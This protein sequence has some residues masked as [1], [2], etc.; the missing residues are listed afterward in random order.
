MRR[1][2]DHDRAREQM[3]DRQIAARGVT[4][5]AVL[6]AMRTVP[7]H[8]FVPERQVRFAYDDSPQPIGRGQTISQP[9]V[10]AWMTEAAGVGPDSRVLEVGTGSGY[11]A[12]VLGQIAREV[13]TIET[14]PELA[15]SAAKRLEDLGY[16]NVTVVEGDGT[17]GLPEHAPFDAIVVTAGGPRIPPALL[18]QLAEGGRLVI[19]VESGLGDQRLVCVRR[20]GDEFTETELGAVRFVPLVGEQAWER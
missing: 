13:L 20:V 17:L 3:V 1:N 15:E 7:R 18:E 8:L 19:P 5:P 11:G 4:D 9:Y 14:I 10:V 12:A 2:A 16:A 6:A